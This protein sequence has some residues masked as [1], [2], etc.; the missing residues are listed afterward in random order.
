MISKGFR[1][2]LMISIGAHVAV[3]TGWAI[4]PVDPV[5][6]DIER[7]PSS[8]EIY[9]IEPQP[10]IEQKPET[11]ENPVK[12]EEPVPI[13]VETPDPAPETVMVNEKRGAIVDLT[14]SYVRNPPPVYP[15][16]AR[17]KAQE[18]TVLLEVEVLPTGR[19]GEVNVLSS[20]NYP[21]LDRAAL[22][23]VRRWVFKPARRG[24]KLISFWV[25]IP[26]TFELE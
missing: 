11:I 9:L 13:V 14:P 6:F 7:A 21:L 17:A 20:S 2:G 25:E 16:A 26:I 18:G 19:C 12:T 23:S 15:R 5:V 22:K 4:A 8:I 3:L 10:V 1:A 24:S